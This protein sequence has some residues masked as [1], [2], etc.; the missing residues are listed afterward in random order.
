[1]KK[2]IIAETS[3]ECLSEVQFFTRYEFLNSIVFSLSP[4][5]YKLFFYYRLNEGGGVIIHE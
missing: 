4:Y 3:L 2:E 1:M 5:S